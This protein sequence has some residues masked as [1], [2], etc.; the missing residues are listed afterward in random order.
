MNDPLMKRQKEIIT[1]G[2]V[3]NLQLFD[4]ESVIASSRAVPYTEIG[5]DSCL[6]CQEINSHATYIVKTFLVSDLIGSS[7]LCAQTLSCVID[8]TMDNGVLDMP[9]PVVSEQNKV[10]VG[11][12]RVA[13]LK[14]LGL[15]EMP[16]L[17]PVAL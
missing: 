6:V 2:T 9:L 1:L 13:A 8:E 11:R 3:E 14:K 16:C 17:L 4:S 15:R 10:I 5:G 12:Y 7:D